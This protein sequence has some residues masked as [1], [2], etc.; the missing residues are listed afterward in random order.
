L[1]AARRSGSLAFERKLSI[2]A[3]QTAATASIERS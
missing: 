3:D 1:E 2:L